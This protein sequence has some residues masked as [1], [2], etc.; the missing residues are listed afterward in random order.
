M[1][2]KFKDFAIRG[3]VMDMTVGV[4]I[5]GAFGKIVTS[6][7]NDMLMPVIGLFTSGM[8]LSDVKIVMR[9]ATD[10]KPEN[11]LR[12]GVFLQTCLDFLI[13]AM[14]IFI[15][16]NIMQKLR[17]KATHTDEKDK[18]TEP[19]PE[20]CTATEVELLTEIRDLLKRDAEE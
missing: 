16:V 11:V 19:E 7:V 3:N 12:I 15:M 10:T 20:I 18:Q 4:I 1:L 13:I 2:K 9:A 5:G 14:F 6:L 17:E 8:N